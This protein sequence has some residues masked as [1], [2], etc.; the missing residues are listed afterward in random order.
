MSASGPF[1]DVSANVLN[2]TEGAHI[3]DMSTFE[4]DEHLR[5]LT[6]LPSAE[7][8][9]AGGQSKVKRTRYGGLDGGGG[10]SGSTAVVRQ[11]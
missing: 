1:S 6:S 9:S 2:S 5:E 10:G 3:K 11:W 7:V 8:E 4:A